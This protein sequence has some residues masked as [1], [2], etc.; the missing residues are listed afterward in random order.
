[1]T[2]K[3]PLLSHCP[4]MILS[5]L[6]LILTGCSISASADIS[7]RLQDSSNPVITWGVKYDTNL[8]GLYNIEEQ[9]VQGFEIDIA[10][11]VT[12]EVLGEEGKAEF[13][14]VNTRNRVPMLKNGNVDAVIGAFVITEERREYVDF[15]DP[16]LDAGQS[17]LVP[18]DSE[19]QSIDDI[20][21][22]KTVLGVKGAMSVANI[23]RISPGSTVLEFD[24][25]TEAFTAL[26][27]GQ[28]DAVT[29][30]DGMLF[31]IAD[32]NPGYRLAGEKFTD[33]PYGIGFDLGQE[34]FV[35][36]VNEALRSMRESGLYDEIYRKWFPDL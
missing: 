17:L 10:K 21:E 30:D 12:K 3:N 4:V 1:M 20:D 27:S 36:K 5:L 11:A 26:Q 9:E 13:I 16:Y 29:T 14:E 8:F 6:L 35:A 32:Q 2:R 22:T 28:G 24:N 33:N 31:G 19:I 15:S 25:I 7:Q 23:R 34:D 18:E